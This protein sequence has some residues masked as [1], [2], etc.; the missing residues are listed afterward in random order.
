LP[1]SKKTVFR[2][3]PCTCAFIANGLISEAIKKIMYFMTK[4]LK[5]ER[6]LAGSWYVKRAEFK[7]TIFI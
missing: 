6:R 1:K 3:L 7:I 2:K 4:V 5:M